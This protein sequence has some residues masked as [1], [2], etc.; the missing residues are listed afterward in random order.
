MIINRKWAM[1]NKWTFQ[2][3]PIK[4]LLNKYVGDGK[5][6]IDPFAGENSPAEITN[7]LNPERPTKFHLY[8]HEFAEQLKETYC[9]VLFDPPYNL[10][11]IKECYDNI[12]SD[13]PDNWNLDASFGKVKDVLAN[14]IKAG[15]LAIS[16]GWSSG[17]FGKKRGFEIEEILLVPHGGHHYDTIVVV[18]RKIQDLFN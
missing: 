8:A 16:F 18:E 17:G 2:I 6:W 3:Q 1:P 5:D 10:S 4:E 9:G 7:D 11:Q 15:G 12:G 14:K 13:Y